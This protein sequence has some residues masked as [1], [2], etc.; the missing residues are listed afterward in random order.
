M[1]ECLGLGLED[2][3][4]LH[5]VAFYRGELEAIRC[6]RKPCLTLYV[7]KHLKKYNIIQGRQ[8]RARRR[9][10][11][12]GRAYELTAYGAR[13]LEDTAPLRGAVQVAMVLTDIASSYP[14]EKRV[15]CL[16]CGNENTVPLRETRIKCEK[17]GATFC[18]P[19]FPGRV[20]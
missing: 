8:G 18:V 1:T 7:L 6:G 9:G 15:R 5:L 17:C 16:A 14:E 10:K 3:S 4:D 20:I 13:L 19:F 12:M 11:P 2:E